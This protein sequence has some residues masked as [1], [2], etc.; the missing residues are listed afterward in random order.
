MSATIDDVAKKAAV[1]TATVSRALRG[2]PN[3]AQ[4]TRA[5]VLKIAAELNYA[6]HPHVTRMLSG[7]KVI[8]LITP[9]VDQWF[10]SKLATVTSLELLSAGY[11][12]ARYSVDSGEA[13]T[14]LVKQLVE[15]QLI[16]G[17]IVVSLPLE[18]ELIAL[19]QAQSI[20]VIT[21]ESRTDVF[22]S[23]SIDNVAAGALGARHLINL[24]H[25]RIGLISSSS[26][27]TREEL[28]PNSRRAGYRQ[29]LA[30]AGITHDSSL[31]FEGNDV[32]E[33]GA[34]A[35]KRLFLVHEPPT[36]VFALS[37]EMAIGALK[38]LRDL[39]LRV[40]EDVSVLGFD[41]NDV[42]EYVGLT[43][44]KQPVTEFA[45]LA[46]TYISEVFASDEPGDLSAELATVLP[47][48]LVL[49]STTGP[50]RSPVHE[51]VF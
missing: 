44:V 24:G 43:T 23:I 34:E 37:D 31:E 7:R 3:V 4:S 30:E 17:C 20:P 29:A 45:E 21:I 9:L 46:A 36:A 16:D 18:D 42:S 19:L 40:P 15:R 1:S 51:D 25:R 35:M 2:L 27:L 22:P 28:I 32:Y 5:H 33:G 10:F 38:T 26:Q 11:D 47:F 48:E 12:V 6:V 8:A 13:Q 41:D 39:N 49:R 14:V 50:Y